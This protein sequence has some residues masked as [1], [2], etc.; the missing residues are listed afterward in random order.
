VTGAHRVPL[1]RGVRRPAPTWHQAPVLENVAIG[2][3]YRRL[4]LRAP[5]IARLA[6]AGQFVMLTAARRPAHGPVLP[7]P[8]AIHHRDPAV[9]VIEVV[10][11]VVGHGTRQL[12]TFGVGESMLVVGPLGHGFEIAPNTRRILVVGR[13]IG[14][15]SLALAA[16]EASARC[17]RIVVVASARS[18]AALLG[19]EAYRDCRIDRRYEVTD[20]AGTSDVRAVRSV[21]VSDLDGAPPDQILVCGSRRLADLCDELGGRWSVPVQESVEAHMACGIGYCHGCASGPASSAGEPP[22]VCVDG[23]VFSRFVPGERHAS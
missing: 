8:M 4:V 13:G 18:R 22:L 16:S 11:G 21:L 3:R 7:R 10:Y 9:G 19:G 6:R 14:T 15:C 12:A 5:S 17:I 20:D 2:D 1:E 23:P